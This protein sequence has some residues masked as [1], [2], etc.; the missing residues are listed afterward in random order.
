MI[1]RRPLPRLRNMT[2]LLRVDLRF[3]HVD[4]RR[5]ATNEGFVRRVDGA[6]VS[7]AGAGASREALAGHVGW[8]LLASVFAHDNSGC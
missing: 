7:L 2:T 6:R 3:E 4:L 8:G 1:K 5:G